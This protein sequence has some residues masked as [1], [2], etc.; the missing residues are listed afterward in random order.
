MND[1]R[2]ASGSDDRSSRVDLAIRL[3][4]PDLAADLVPL[5]LAEGPEV[6]LHASAPVREGHDRADVPRAR[7]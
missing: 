3:G 2:S 6:R 1:S 4:P 7:R 5:L